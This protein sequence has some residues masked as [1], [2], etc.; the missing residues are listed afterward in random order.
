MNKSVNEVSYDKDFLK[1]VKKLPNNL[2]YKLAGLIEIIRENP[3]NPKLHTKPL[4]A[5]LQGMFSFRIN[6]DYRVGFKYITTHCIQLLTVDRRD[7]IYKQ[8]KRKI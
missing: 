1:D 4:S 2:Q 7:K 3:F 5:P 6:R 8:L